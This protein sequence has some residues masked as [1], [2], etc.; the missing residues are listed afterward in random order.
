[1]ARL[2]SDGPALGSRAVRSVERTV[3]VI[4]KDLARLALRWRLLRPLLVAVA[5]RPWPHGRL[6]LADPWAH[7]DPGLR[8]RALSGQRVGLRFFLGSPSRSHRR[9]AAVFPTAHR[10][11]S[12]G[13]DPGRESAGSHH[14][15][16]IFDRVVS[17]SLR[18]GPHRVPRPTLAPC[19]CLSGRAAV[20]SDPG[21]GLD[22]RSTAGGSAWA[23]PPRRHDSKPVDPCLA[24]PTHGTQSPSS[25]VSPVN[26]TSAILGI[27]I[28]PL[29][30]CGGE[31]ATHRL[32]RQSARAWKARARH[33]WWSRRCCSCCE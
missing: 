11:W 15:A 32:R 8:G 27:P 3:R 28:T 17:A 26:G 9:R 5:V 30:V 29:T 23:G 6:S 20:C 13:A 1:M 12:S 10:H 16:G 25:R 18:L 19:V 4:A 31:E 21:M 2:A 22:A 33:G 7:G 14:R 24:E